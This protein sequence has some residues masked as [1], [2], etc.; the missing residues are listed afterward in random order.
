M[1]ARSV[2]VCVYVHVKM[3]EWHQWGDSDALSM[4]NSPGL[5]NKA[6]L[7]RGTSDVEDQTLAV[8]IRSSQ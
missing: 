6:L 8:I 5:P 1:N 3:N 4:F 2:L 7:G